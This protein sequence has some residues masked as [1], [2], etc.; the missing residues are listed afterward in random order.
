[1]KK[2]FRIVA[3]ALVSMMC[4]TMLVACDQDSGNQHRT[5]PQPS[6]SQTPAPQPV[7]SQAPETQIP[8]IQPIQVACIGDSITEGEYPEILGTLIAAEYAHCEV[9]NFGRGG[10][11]ATEGTA[12]SYSGMKDFE[13]SIAAGAE[14]YIIMLGTNDT[15]EIAEFDES[16]FRESYAAL[17]DAYMA[18][19]PE[20]AIYTMLCPSVFPEEETGEVAFGLQ[21]DQLDNSVRPIIGELSAERGLPIIDLYTYTQEHPEWFADGIHPNTIGAEAIAA[22]IFEVIEAEIAKG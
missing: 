18:A 2:C 10:A 11:R 15:L 19:N 8:E 6:Q 16:A 4:I 9:L 7:E 22:Y 14:V 17:L 5:D 21:V 12:F 3:L 1:M 20:A 13:E